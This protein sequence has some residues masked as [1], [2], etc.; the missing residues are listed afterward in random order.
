MEHPAGEINVEYTRDNA[1]VNAQI[2][3]PPGV[4]GT[5]LWRGREYSLREGPQKLALPPM[6]S[7]L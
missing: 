2:T 3:L 6:H 5:L 7:A 1:G 4:S